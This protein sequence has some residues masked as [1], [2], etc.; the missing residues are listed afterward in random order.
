MWFVLR[1]PGVPARREGGRATRRSIQMAKKTNPRSHIA[2]RRRLAKLERELTVQTQ[3]VLESKT[4]W[5]GPESLFWDGRCVERK[6][7][8]WCLGIE[9][10]PFNS[11]DVMSGW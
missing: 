6:T 9:W 8:M 2:I 7:L 11:A 4:G 1:R 3:E 5:G 10:K